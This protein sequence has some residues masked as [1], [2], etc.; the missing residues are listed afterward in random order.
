MTA[1][2]STGNNFFSGGDGNDSFNF[3][4]NSV[5]TDLSDLVI[6]TVDGGNGND[7]L[8]AIYNFTAGGI[9]S[10][11]NA[12]TNTGS[13]TVGT[14][15]V[16]YNNIE[17]LNISGTAYDDLIVG[18]NGNDTLK[19]YSGNDILT[20]SKGNDTLIGEYGTDTFTFNSFNEGVDIINDFNATTI[21]ELIQ[22]SAAGFGGGL[23]SG[24][25]QVSQL[26]IGTSATTNTQR[27]IYN[28]ATGGLFF[29]QDGSKSGFTQV[30]FA[31]LSTGLSLSENNF[32]VV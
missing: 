31:Q 6:Q 28:S 27:F 7:S 1:D 18:S 22:V 4:T 14:Y 16:N 25:L 5:D 32:V 8:F 12:T 26:T 9:T 30:Q 2:Y 20:G 15:R 24:S 3:I 13:I 29:D 10:T 11:F 19:G 21:N 23:S 17:Q